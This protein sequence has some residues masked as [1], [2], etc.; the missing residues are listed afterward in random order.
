MISLLQVIRLLFTAYGCLKRRNREQCLS[1]VVQA[2]ALLSEWLARPDSPAELPGESW[3]AE[4]QRAWDQERFGD[5][6][7]PYFWELPECH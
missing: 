3:T 1:L 6:E 4:E 7:E 2:Y 5:D